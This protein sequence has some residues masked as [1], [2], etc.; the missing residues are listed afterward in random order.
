[1]KVLS[2]IFTVVAILAAGGAATVH[3]INKDK[4]VVLDNQLAQV[5]TEL[6]TVKSDLNVSVAEARKNE[7]LLKNVRAELADAK[8]QN[9][10]IQRELLETRTLANERATM[11]QSNAQTVTT[12]KQETERLRQEL[13]KR[14]PQREVQQVDSASAAEIAEY[15]SKISELEAT[16]TTLR[17][18]LAVSGQ[19]E[20]IL[21]GNNLGDPMNLSPDG[22]AS[23]IAKID[24]TSGFIVLNTGIGSGIQ[25]SETYTLTKAG[26]TLARIIVSNV[27][28][29]FTVAKILPDVGI[30]NSLRSGDSVLVQR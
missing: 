11:V 13:L 1:M 28:P 29:D 16:I 7:Q 9:T 4:L 2:T 23:E 6:D 24:T 20:T 10:K 30:P 14:A 3:L 12:L 22:V 18:K 19:S 8:S 15:Q 26:Y 25:D 21:A 5:S 17:T 27:P